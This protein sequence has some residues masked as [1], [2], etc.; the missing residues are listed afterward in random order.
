[1]AKARKVQNK[2]SI[3]LKIRQGIEKSQAYGLGVFIKKALKSYRRKDKATLT[4]FSL[5]R[6][7]ER[8]GPLLLRLRRS[9]FLIFVHTKQVIATYAE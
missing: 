5:L 6:R 2:Q 8:K 1:M 7:S 9:R 4:V 3:G